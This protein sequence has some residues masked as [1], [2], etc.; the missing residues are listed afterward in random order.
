MQP[1][2][3]PASPLTGDL[4]E[5]DDCH[6]PR[7]DLV[8]GIVCREQP[9]NK[10]RLSAVYT[11]RTEAYPKTFLT[12]GALKITRAAKTASGIPSDKRIPGCLKVPNRRFQRE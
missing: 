8:P 1:S 9:G 6:T 3:S 7:A 12:S 11:E 5:I 10:Y 2:E 4:Q